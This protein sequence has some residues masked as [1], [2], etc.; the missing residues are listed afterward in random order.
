MYKTT[1]VQDAWERIWSERTVPAEI[2]KGKV[3]Y[4][5]IASLIYSLLPE[6]GTLLEAGCGLGK[7]LV[8]ITTSGHVIHGVDYTENALRRVKSY[9]PA[10]RVA[11][12][13]VQSLPYPSDTF[14]LYVSVGVLEHIIDGPEIGL[15]EA[16]RV[17]RHGGLLFISGPHIAA[18][19]PFR[20]FRAVA[21]RV[22]GLEKMVPAGIAFEGDNDEF[23]EYH[24]TRSQMCEYITK[25]GFRI[26]YKGWF[27]TEE[28]LAK[29]LR[30]ATR[31]GEACR[32]FTDLNIVGRVVSRLV[33]HLG[34]G[35]FSTGWTIVAH[36]RT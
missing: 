19:W 14:D 5:E 24:Y 31:R 26:I 4:P 18:T 22:D 7:F 27:G 21:P 13:D 3:E 16:H 34:G 33:R 29:I 15:R 8:P 32:P 25:Y 36:K 12:G 6:T 10:T 20:V 30:P 28:L 2:E 23:F 1:C 11:V 35:H 17:L 9:A